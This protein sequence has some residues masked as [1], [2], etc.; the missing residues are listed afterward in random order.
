M[1]L[2]PAD[3]GNNSGGY[4]VVK[5]IDYVKYLT[6]KIGELPHRRFVLYL[7]AEIHCVYLNRG[8]YG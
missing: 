2:K 1:I 6:G 8:R 7:Q 4:L 3:E 5:R